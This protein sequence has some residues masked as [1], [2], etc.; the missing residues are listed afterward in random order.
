MNQPS[1]H[2]YEDKLLELAYGELPAAEARS[3]EAHVKG[4]ARCSGALRDIEGVRRQMSQLAAEP[5]PDAGLESLLAY[6]QQTARRI[7]A[8]P[9]PKRGLRKL[10][11][12]VVGFASAAAVV[13]AVTT[14]TLRVKDEVAAPTA[15]FSEEAK[16]KEQNKAEAAPEVPPASAPA[17]PA[18]QAQEPAYRQEAKLQEEKRDAPARR[19]EWEGQQAGPVTGA[20][21]PIPKDKAAG[22]IQEVDVIPESDS[23]RKAADALDTRQD[24]VPGRGTRPALPSGVSTSSSG[25][26]RSKMAG[27]PA[28][29][30]PPEMMLGDRRPADMDNASTDTRIAG[31][32]RSRAK[33][34]ADDV[35]AGAGG[36]F[37]ESKETERGGLAAADDEA[38]RQG[39]AANVA[40]AKPAPAPTPVPAQ[41]PP[42]PSVDPSREQAN[43]GELASAAA[44]PAE[45]EAEEDGMLALRRAEESQ[46]SKKSKAATRP[47]SALEWFT[48]ANQVRGTPEEPVLLE[49]AIDAGL[50]GSFR[51]D[52]LQRLCL[53]FEKREVVARAEDFCTEWNAMARSTASKEAVSRVRATRM[54]QER[55]KMLEA[56]EPAQAAP[57]EPVKKLHSF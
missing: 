23:L 14:V 37:G 52:A 33:N 17:P 25:L 27:P 57:A 20:K 4:C 21:V 3:V 22:R 10:L 53:W 36:G 29:P 5:A 15:A 28:A 42:S 11:F 16:T 45:A 6:A 44:S 19:D 12:G 1:A 2:R 31:K 41:A 55:A 9:E 39:L 50:S 30:P 40:P 51:M 24:Y 18:M 56:A 47:S 38:P 13:V 48:R 34:V 54:K 49:R 7:Q 43:K 46:A 32:Q 26:Q 8:G 35:L